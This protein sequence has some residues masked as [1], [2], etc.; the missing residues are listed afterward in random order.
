SLSA[1]IVQPPSGTESVEDSSY[2]ACAWEF[3]AHLH[4]QGVPVVLVVPADRSLDLESLVA[5]VVHAH[6]SGPA[7]LARTVGQVRRT[8]S[9][10]PADQLVV[11]ASPPADTTRK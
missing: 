8:L 7:Q 1:A 10:I 9:N 3:A 2:V 5:A 4:A 6:D 11:Y